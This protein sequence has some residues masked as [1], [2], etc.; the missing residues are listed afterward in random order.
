MNEGICPDPIAAILPFP[1]P[2]KSTFRVL[3]VAE[4]VR[5]PL[6]GLVPGEFDVTDVQQ[7]AD[8]S[9]ANVA[10]TAAGLLQSRGLTADAVS[11]EGEP[12][13]L[14]AEYAKTW[15]ADLIVVGACDR[16]RIERVLVGSVS[17]SVVKH[18]CCSVLV[19]KAGSTEADAQ[20]RV[21]VSELAHQEPSETFA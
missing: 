10:S 6:A 5:P 7:A 12:Q 19:V 3:T 20:R 15:G 17:Q 14:I 11:F 1:W 21:S 16:S 18:S 8:A 4:L 13:S 2:A 9:A